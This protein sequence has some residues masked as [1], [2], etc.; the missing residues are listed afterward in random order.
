[1]AK[2]VVFN[3]F[4][5]NFDIISE[6]TIGAFGSTPNVSGLALDASQILTLQPADATNPGGV[7]TGT[8]TIAG[9]KTFNAI[10]TV[11]TAG[12][13]ISLGSQDAYSRY[14]ILNNMT[15]NILRLGTWQSDGDATNVLSEGFVCYGD[16]LLGNPISATEGGYARI[17]PNR[18]GLFTVEPTL[19]A[20]SGGA[21]YFRLDDVQAYYKDNAGNTT[22]SV[23]RETGVMALGGTHANATLGSLYTLSIGTVISGT[24]TATNFYAAR[25]NPQIRNS[26]LLTNCSILRVEPSFLDTANSTNG[27][28]VGYFGLSSVASLPSAIGLNVDISTA[29]VTNPINA[30]S[31]KA[32]GGKLDITNDFTLPPTTTLF[33]SHTIGGALTL[34]AGT[35][36]AAF[37]YG[38]N[39]AQSLTVNENWNVDP[40]GIRLGYSNVAMVGNIVVASGKTMNSW[41]GA[42]SGLANTSGSGTIDQVSFF[43]TVGALAQGGT[44]SATNIYGFRADTLL[45]NMSHTNVWGVWI[46]DT[47]ADNWFAKNVVIGGATGQPTGAYALDVAGAIRTNTSLVLEDPGAGTNTVT[48]QAPTVAGSYTLTLPVSGGTSGYVLSTDG[49]GTTSWVSAGSLGTYIVEKF[50]LTG[51]DITNGYVTLASTPSAPGDSVLSVIGGPVQDYSVDYTI[52]GAQ[53]DWNGLFLDGVLVAGDKLI[54]QYS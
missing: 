2:S 25:I 20:Y 44:V 49:S 30:T 4:T 54:V 19:A 8:Q 18:F 41:T 1:M 47:N 13:S 36:T 16:S 10:T 52:T 21:Y 45:S 32:R 37:G 34:A 17:K 33:S 51:T 35:S 29:I 48:L 46:G 38:T 14:Q 5:G 15:A 24:S 11:T 9:A 40:T 50:T 22:F 27:V 31:I 6:I 26:S 7:S 43:R 3:P 23:Q 28:T 53:L 12:G 42:L 39:L